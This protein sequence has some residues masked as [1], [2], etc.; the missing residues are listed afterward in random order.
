MDNPVDIP[1]QT[2]VDVIKILDLKSKGL[3]SSAIA[4]LCNCSIGTVHYHLRKFKT[5][6]HSLKYYKQVETDLLRLKVKDMV[7]S[8]D[9]AKIKDMAGRDLTTCIAILIDKIR[10]LED[11]STQNISFRGY[12]ATYDTLET[13]KQAI[14]SKL[15][16]LKHQVELSGIKPD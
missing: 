10:L 9:A 1:K 3:Q 7:M 8:L 11:K 6:L 14:E 5:R 4:E 16:E 15:A 13:Q 12:L 2:Q